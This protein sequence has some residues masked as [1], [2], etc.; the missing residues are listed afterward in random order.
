MKFNFVENPVTKLPE[1][2]FNAKL[3]SDAPKTLITYENSKGE[4]RQYGIVTIE[5]ENSKGELQQS[6]ASIHESNLKY[7]IE[8]G[9]SYLC[10]V[11]VNPATNQA[12]LN[13][14]HLTGAP[15]ADV[16]AFGFV[17]AEVTQGVL[18]AQ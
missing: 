12:W 14:S 10:K 6:S 15:R 8:R 11:T 16:S 3:V 13:M 2:Q 18:A 5:F 9:T 1:A 17:G 4:N 7:G